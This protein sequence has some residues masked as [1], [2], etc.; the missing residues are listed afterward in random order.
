MRSKNIIL[1]FTY[2]LVIAIIQ[3]FAKIRYRLH[4]TKEGV[5]LVRTHP[6]GKKKGKDEKQLIKSHVIDRKGKTSDLN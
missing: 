4:N 1:Q 3:P 6:G 2:V 5:L